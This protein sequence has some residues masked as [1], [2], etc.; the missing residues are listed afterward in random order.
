MAESEEAARVLIVEHDE[1]IAEALQETLADEGYDASAIVSANDLLPSVRDRAPDAIA[2]DLPAEHAKAGRMLDDLRSDP[3]TG[4]IPVIAMSTLP[5][6]A[7]AARASFNVQSSLV[8]PFDLEA[9]LACVEQALVRPPL[10]AGLDPA[11]QPE[12]VRAEAERVLA[13]AS[14]ETLL[15]FAERLRGDPA[16]HSQPTLTLGEA[17]E[18][19]P[20]IVE[21]VDASL[22]LE[23]PS[24]LIEAHPYVAERLREHAGER[25]DRGLPLDA[26]VREFTL[27][28]DELWSLLSQRMPTA[29]SA[30]AVFELERAVNGTLDRIM[31][32]T[33][34]VLGA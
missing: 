1:P 17:L 22:H 29:T 6:I 28:R 23:Q 16:W 33:I 5:S 21:A 3:I 26:L 34:P 15:R 2:L 30:A 31:E 24:Q 27:L 10:H 9:F 11:N 18:S 4:Q 8:K 20:T 32:V 13:E 25:R 14:R 19:A 12:G 7:E